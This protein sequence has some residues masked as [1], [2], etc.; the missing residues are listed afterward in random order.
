MLIWLAVGLFLIFAVATG[1]EASNSSS[2]FY[3]SSLLTLDSPKLLFRESVSCSSFRCYIGD[4]M[5][6][7]ERGEAFY[8]IWLNLHF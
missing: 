4:M 1:A 8:N 5:E 3:L 2:V 7:N 6:M